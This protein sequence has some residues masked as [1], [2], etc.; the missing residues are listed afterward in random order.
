M[1]QKLSNR[2]DIPNFRA[3]AILS[4][5]NGRIADGEDIVRLEAGQPSVGAPAQAI[6]YAKEIL[7]SDP[8]QGYTEAIG[9]PLLR[10]R[11]GVHYRDTEGIDV[12]YENVALSV[13]SSA[14]FILV[15]LAAFD[16]GDTVLLTTPTYPAYRN[17]LKSLGINV[18][19]VET[20]MATNYQPTVEIL[21]NF[22][23]KFDGIILASPCNPTGTIIDPVELE[24]ICK[25][26]DENGVRIISDEAY[27]GITYDTPAKTVLHYSKTAVVTNTFSKYFAMTGWRLGWMVVPDD[28]KDRIK[29]LSE[30]LFVSPPALSQ[31][32]A[33]KVFDHLDVLDGYVDMYRRNRDMLRAELPKA[34]F[35]KLSSCDGAFYIYADVHA[36]TNDS[37]AFCRTMLNEAGVSCT[38]G[39][40][41]DTQRG[42][43]TIRISYAGSNDDIAQACERIKKWRA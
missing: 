6:E 8:K 42:N 36:L 10:D 2:S 20:T 18:V 25:W 14:G 15:F 38:P 32:L 35:D 40:D 21:S 16:H 12:S 5:V 1:V 24:K 34:G 41:F 28:L 26:C 13:G 33:Y 7:S 17:I 31:H 3:L 29:K 43:S 27:H 37:E 30:S 22:D 9:M 19:E 39:L 4:E 23:Q 11:I